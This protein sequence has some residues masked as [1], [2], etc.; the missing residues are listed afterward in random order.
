MEW[1]PQKN[2]RVRIMGI[3]NVTPDSFS[4][5]GQFITED[6]IVAQAAAMVAAGVDIIDVGGESTRPFASPISIQEECDR[7]LSAIVAIRRRFPTPISIDTTKSPV[8]R[9]ALANGADIINDI[10]ALRFDPEMIDLVKSSEVPVIIMHMKGTPENM[11]VEPVYQNV[12]AEISSFLEERL[13]WAEEMGVARNRFIVDP[14]IGFG[15]TV[16][17]NLL[18]LKHLRDFSKLKCPLLVGHSR[19]SFIG[20]VLDKEV[21]EREIGT[22]A[23]S[24]I[25][26]LHGADI[27][28]VHDVDSTMQAVKMAAAIMQVS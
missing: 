2:G 14:G 25:A 17:H 20:K 26:M 19:K 27:L 15:K 9:E 16:T 22:A 5:G 24:V 18:I 4:D 12:L 7:V 10:S 1:I 8:A 6:A 13:S 23:V 28:R 21:T 11:Q 3:L